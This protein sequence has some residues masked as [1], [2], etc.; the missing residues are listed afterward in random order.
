L[1]D[2]KKTRKELTYSWDCGE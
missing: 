2:S 1:F